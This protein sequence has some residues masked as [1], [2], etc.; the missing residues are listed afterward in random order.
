MTA[1]TGAEPPHDQRARVRASIVMRGMANN[2]YG[3]EDIVVAL[4]KANLPANRGYIKSY[5][6]HMAAVERP[7][8]R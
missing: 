2:G 3:L 4:R 7:L 1:K 6:L 5:V 8:K